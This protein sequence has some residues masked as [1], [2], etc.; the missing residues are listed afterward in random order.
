MSENKQVAKWT[1]RAIPVHSLNESAAN[2]QAVHAELLEVRNKYGEITPEHALEYAKN[3]KTVLHRLLTWNDNAAAHQYRLLQLR[4]IIHNVQVSVISN[5]QPREITAN[6]TISKDLK[7]AKQVNVVTQD[8]IARLK[9]WAFRNL[10]DVKNKLIG[11]DSFNQAVLHLNDAITAVVDAASG[12]TKTSR[13]ILDDV[14]KNG[15]FY[16]INGKDVKPKSWKLKG[17]MVWMDC[18]VKDGGEKTVKMEL[19]DIQEVFR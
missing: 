8:E 17:D 13:Q 19:S 7:D 11:Y 14:V 15:K 6:I 12:K 9:D 18:E 4:W 3:K 2:A 10:E 16:H 5:G 1:D